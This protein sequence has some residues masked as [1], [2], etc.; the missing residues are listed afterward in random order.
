[1][2]HNIKNK[3]VIIVLIL[4]YVIVLK[5]LVSNFNLSNIEQFVSCKLC[6]KTTKAFKLK[7]QLKC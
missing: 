2:L 4:I 6:L 1:M 7:L 5:N 3:I